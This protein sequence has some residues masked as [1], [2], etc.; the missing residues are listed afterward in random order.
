MG[1]NFKVNRVNIIAKLGISLFG[2]LAFS[3]TAYAQ[4]N[5]IEAISSINQSGKEIVKIDFSQ[6]LTKAPEGFSIQTPARIALDF[7]GMANAIGKNLVEINY[8]NLKSANVVQV[9]DRTRVVLNLKQSTP[10]LPTV[11]GKSLLVTLNA[12][13]VQAAEA[14]VPAKTVA[15]VTKPVAVTQFAQNGNSS[16]LPIR[17]MDFRRGV[18]GS[19]RLII[20][21]PNNQV[22]VDIKQ[23]GAMLALEF[24]KTSLP[25]GLRR[26]LDVADFGTPIQMITAYQSGDKVKIMVEARGEW[27]HSAY[28]GDNQFVLEVRQQKTDPDKLTKGVGYSGEKL[29]LNF[30]NIEIRSLLQVIADFT[31]FNI[32]TSDSVSGSLTL[33]LKDVPWDQ[34]LD[35]ILQAKGLGVKKS[36]NVL[37]VAP[38]EELAAKEKQELE[39]KQAVQGLEPLRTQSFQLNYVKAAD[40]KAQITQSSGSSGGKDAASILSARGSVIAEPRTNQLF[41]TDIPSRL[42]A[43]QQ[44]ISKLDIAV[45]QVLIEARIVEASDSFGKSLG[46][47][48]GG[49]DLRGV[50]GGD[51][52]YKV[53]GDNRIAFGGSYSA[54]GKTTGAVAGAIDTNEATFVGLPAKGLGGVNPASLG[55]SLFSAAANRFLMLEISALE[56]DGRGKIVSSPR[57]ITADQT[58]AIIEQGTELPYQTATSSGATAIEWK[59]ANL[60]L[61]V[62]PQITPEGSIILDLDVNKDS[63]GRETFLGFA[64]DTK[65]VQTQVLIENGGTVVIGGIFELSERSTETKVPFLGDLPAVGNLF[66]SRSKET[67]KKEL[68]V[69]ITPKIVSEKS[70]GS[71]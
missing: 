14:V 51:A 53:S 56:A 37:W 48:L 13:N 3:F 31:N 24:Q 1:K 42:E 61:E 36:G 63:V 40:L 28:Q 5:S 38:K 34:A 52:G 69:F 4:S 25:E 18:D 47:K 44:L 35:I 21:L 17:D 6:P 33:R 29:S 68:I 20:E 62:T 70:F 66:K 19:G 60:K 2:A 27:Q 22:G 50:R 30:Q 65:H 46:V 10:Y 45:R 57:V 8:G 9:G 64:I 58:K 41:V 11:S 54:V 26:K 39:A 59:K 16:I 67:E 7:P 49:A 15:S 12:S 32:I 71:R 23:Q 43:V 55:I